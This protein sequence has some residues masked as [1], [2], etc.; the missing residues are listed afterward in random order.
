MALFCVAC[1][2]DDPAPMDHDA[3][4]TTTDTTGDDTTGDETTGDDTTGDETTGDDTTGD[5]TTGDETTDT[6]GDETTGDDTTG[7]ETTGDDTTDTTD[8]TGDDTTD[9]GDDTTD[10]GGGGVSYA[11]DV[12]PI[13]AEKCSGG[14]CHNG[15]GAGGHNLAD[16]LDDGDKA[17]GGQCGDTTDK[18]SC[19]VHRINNGTMPQGA[20]CKDNPDGA[21]CLTTEQ[22]ATVQAWA[23]GGYLP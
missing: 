8:T 23:D 21:G 10:T 7:D 2:D 13:F 19:S 9:T 6:T 11:S 15:A 5:E 17:A 20:G 4:S 16:N 12:Q 3:H 22:K 18:K 14:F 1:G